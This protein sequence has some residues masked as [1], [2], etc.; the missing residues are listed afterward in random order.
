[1]V[2]VKKL[3]KGKAVGPDDIAIEQYQSSK[4]ACEELHKV[5]VTIFDKED[6]PEEFVTADMLML[7]K[8]KS[9]DVRSNYRALGLL[10]HSYKAFSRVLLM[11]IIPFIAPRLSDMQA[12]FR[13]GRGCRDNILILTM[14]IQ[15]LLKSVEGDQCA[16]VITYID[17]VAAFDSIYHSYMLQSLKQYGV[18][19]KYVRLVRAIYQHAA[20]RVRMQEK[21]GNRSYSRNIPVRRGAI[22]GDIPSPVVFL[23]A[24]DR[25]LKDHGGLHTGIRITGGLRLSDLEF[26]DDAALANHDASEASERMT[27][28]C[29]Q[30]KPAGMEISIPKTF[31]QHICHQPKVSQTTE[32]DIANLPKEKQFKFECDGCGMKY[33]THQGMAL[34]RT[35]FCKRSKTA[36]KPS[37]KG[38][39]ADRIITRVKVEEHQKI[40]PKVKMGDNE[41]KNVYSAVYLGAEV[42]SDGDQKVTLK[43]RSDIAWARFNEYRTT[44]TSTKLPISLRIRLHIVLVVQTLIYGSSA[45]LLDEGLR[46]SVNGINSKMVSSITKRSIHEEAREPSFRIMDHILKR[47]R[48]YLGHI[49]RMPPDRMVRRF[50]LELNPDSAPFIPGS[51]LDD[52]N[53]TTVAEM[54]E[55]ASH[56]DSWSED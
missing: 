26:A 10:N 22:Q 46:R 16:G 12:G 47:R 11:R 21:G 6:V 32:E 8:K 55:A 9:K 27:I 13:T 17:F 23:V 49:L 54:I 25:L 34:H 4:S 15:H 48:A 53:Y 24:L 2:C 14:A 31:V 7:Y 1:M 52:T 3:N 29:E 19:L 42:P 18:P 45:W 20:V 41:L 35:R 51:L 50:L 33:P 5:I 43:H 30:A 37:R 40:L 39:V 56:R 36:K 28:L 44:L 38:T